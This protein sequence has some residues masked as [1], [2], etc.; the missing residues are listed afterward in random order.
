MM[1]RLPFP[2]L[3]AA[4]L[5]VAF[6]PTLAAQSRLSENA[7]DSRFSDVPVITDPFDFTLGGYIIDLDTAAAIGNNKGVGS[8]IR[9]EEILGL[10]SHQQ[11]LRVGF[12][13]DFARKHSIG[14]VWFSIS[15]G[16]IGEFDETIDF[17]D[18]RF[19]GEYESQ[20]DVDY[21]GLDYRYS[22][23]NNNRVD[24]GFSLGVSTFDFSVALEGEAS[25]IGGDEPDPEIEYR[26]A[27]ADIIAP[28]PAIG[29][30]IDYAVTRRLIVGS[31]VQFVDLTI[32]GYQGRFMDLAFTVDWFFSRHFAIGGGLASTDISV[33]YT[34]DDPYRVDYR[35]SGVL[36]HLRGS[37]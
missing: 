21:Y 34:G 19:V 5:L 26:Q 36:F 30:F 9:L 37:F 16:A 20:F 24:A 7:L 1:D 35:Y 27:A 29:M 18:L 3:T 2:E 15:R 14:L 12:R 13:W 25:V 6:A 28:V 4:V 31:S 22:L 8:L 32:S 17:E 23:I 33:T 11:L 10:E